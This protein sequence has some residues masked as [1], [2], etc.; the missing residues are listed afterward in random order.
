MRASIRKPEV[1]RPATASRRKPHGRRWA[2][3][4]AVLSAGVLPMAL[5]AC[6]VQGSSSSGSSAKASTKAGSP[7]TMHAILSVTGSASFLGGSEKAAL[8][9]MQKQV[10]STGG[11]QGHPLNIAIAD[12]QSVASTAVS[13]ASPLVGQ[14]PLLI[15]GALTT[16]DRPVDNLATSKGPV[17]YDLSP[18]DHPA[19]GSSVYSASNSTTSQTKAFANFAKMKGW[20]RVAAIT[21]T[22]TSGQDGWTN[23]Q[24]AVAGSGGAVSV[25]SHQ[26]FDPKAV[27]VTTQLSQIKAANPQALFI[28]TTGT[29]LATVFK[30]MQQLGMGSLATMTTN[31]N[32]SAQQMHQLANVLPAQLF[33]PGA[34]FQVGPQGLTGE[35]KTAVQTF[36]SAMKAQGVPV[37]SEGNALAWDPALLLVSALK[38]LGVNATGAQINHYIATQTSF[39]GING[40]YNFVNSPSPDNR[41]LGIS[42]IYI[43]RWDPSQGHWVAASGPSGQGAPPSGS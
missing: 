3:G 30:G 9:A 14:V 40:T 26:T 12:N 31:G 6:G 42:S 21:S 23:I 29:P 32:A 15:V 16:V 8:L 41:G 5:A 1:T 20:K 36:D 25:I 7:Y 17:I 38:K 2:A 10:N 34:P 35:E 28:W 27:S 33:F 11:I 37:A 43:T 18:G 4:L 39:A 24:K 22:D 19:R 13:L